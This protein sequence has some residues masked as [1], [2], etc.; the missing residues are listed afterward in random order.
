MSE[1]IVDQDLNYFHH[2]MANVLMVVRGYAE[3]MLLRGRLDP[4]MRRYPEQLI[5]A[6]DHAT[7]EL[8]RLHSSGNKA[9]QATPASKS[10]E[11]ENR[12]E[13][14]VRQARAMRIAPDAEYRPPRDPRDG[15]G[16]R[17]ESGL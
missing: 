14:A 16:A 2:E 12:A 5:L 4:E 10:S 13:L 3:L 8:E 7:R 9:L 15:H 17:L 1:P 11:R 6:V